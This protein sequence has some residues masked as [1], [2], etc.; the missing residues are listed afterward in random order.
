M[1]QLA[2]NDELGCR[3]ALQSKVVYE[4]SKVNVVSRDVF[5]VNDTS[6]NDCLSY[7]G[8]DYNSSPQLLIAPQITS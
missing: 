6:L 3:E 5:R 7:E 2:S 1:L 8:L 4:E